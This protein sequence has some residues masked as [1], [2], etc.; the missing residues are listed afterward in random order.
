MEYLGTQRLSDFEVY[1]AKRF[2]QQH[3]L[4]TGKMDGKLLDLLKKHNI[5]I[6]GGAI[7][8]VFSGAPI[9]DYDLYPTDEDSYQVFKSDFEQ[10][11]KDSNNQRNKLIFESGNA[12]TFRYENKL[13]QIITKYITP[14]SAVYQ[15]SWSAQDVIS[16]FDFTVC[17]G[18][19]NCGTSQWILYPNFLL[20]IA[21]HRLVFNVHS[22][23]PICAMYRVLKY[24]RK[25]YELSASELVKLAL[26]I[27]KLKM[28]SYMDLKEQLMGIDTLIFQ[29]LTDSLINQHGENAPVDF[30]MV[31][32]E[33]DNKL[34]TLWENTDVEEQMKEDN[35][36]TLPFSKE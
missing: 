9:K 21:A 26:S 4:L 34:N 19:F 18:A 20:D 12:L 17:M 28:E 13:Y 16:N 25:G 27:N 23:Y 30:G 15:K 11:L 29:E 14:K 8:S 6:A 5:V 31:M 22:S 33:I 32:R 1:E 36:M 10:L 24:M 3:Y 7:T 2:P 35:A